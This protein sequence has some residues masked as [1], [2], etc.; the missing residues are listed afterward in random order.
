MNHPDALGQHKRVRIEQD[1]QG[2]VLLR[3]TDLATT[4][5]LSPDEALD[6]LQWLYDHRDELILQEPTGKLDDRLAQQHEEQP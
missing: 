4:F 2:N 6:L 3:K 5:S 1:K